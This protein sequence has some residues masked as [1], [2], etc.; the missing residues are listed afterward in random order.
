[1]DGA[2]VMG[3]AGSVEG[4]VVS[5]MDSTGADV[6]GRARRRGRPQR[7]P[8]DPSPLGSTTVDPQLRLAWLLATSRVMSP[9]PDVA[10]RSR[11]I[12]TLR[13]GGLP[14]DASRVSRWESGQLA[15]PVPAILAYART[16]GLAAGPAL[17]LTR[18]LTRHATTQRRDPD[19]SAYDAVSLSTHEL[20]D[21]LHR[22]VEETQNPLRGGDWLQ[23]AICLTRFELVFLGSPAWSAM[24]ARLVSE[25]ARSTGTAQL[26]RYEA[27]STLLT[28][29]LA[30]SAMLRAIGSWLVAP[31]VQVPAPVLMLL[32]EI[33]DRAAGA[34]ALRFL[35]D[36]NR[37]LREAA[38]PV[39][40]VKVSRDNLGAKVFERLESLCLHRLQASHQHRA[41]RQAFDLATRLPEDSIVRIAS[42]MR[43]RALMVRLLAA[44]SSGT[45]VTPDQVLRVSRLVAN[46]VRANAGAH[47]YETDGMLERLIQESL[48]HVHASRRE[49]ASHLLAASPYA[50]QL[51]LR[52]VGLVRGNDEPLALS[53]AEMIAAFGTDPSAEPLL[54]RGVGDSRPAVQAEAIRTAATVDESWCSDHVDD[55]VGL[56]VS[57][58]HKLVRSAA[59]F[60]LGMA[61]SA[62]VD[63]EERLAPTDRPALAWWR[64][65]GALVSDRDGTARSPIAEPPDDDPG[66]PGLHSVD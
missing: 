4:S 43:D 47:R 40:A 62:S 27:A 5:S 26:Q 61:G 21:L 30:K 57:H 49:L 10:T 19:P 37:L 14:A 64:D 13:E 17:S 7:L 36:E 16:V 32:R 9:D 29:P 34:L 18:M 24:C 31:A 51:R 12:V 15:L 46:D 52:L 41:H 39:V 3:S 45:A 65:H 63:L 38:V 8:I 58:P 42:A 59:I 11:F 22:A 2:I 33:D 66:W 1:M 35:G 28:S 50:P 6:A 56:A 48:F 25:L 60:G 23:L 55:L 44:H 53:A 54:D 20:E